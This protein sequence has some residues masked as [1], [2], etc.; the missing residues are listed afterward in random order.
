MSYLC[1]LRDYGMDSL[2]VMEKRPWQRYAAMAFFVFIGGLLIAVCRPL[3]IFFPQN[4]EASAPVPVSPFGNRG[5]RKDHAAK[6]AGL[7]EIR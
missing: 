7:E 5:K 3:L 6:I 1:I 4:A 2:F